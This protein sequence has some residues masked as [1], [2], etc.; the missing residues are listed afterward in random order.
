M[1][2]V[3]ASLELPENRHHRY[4]TGIM[5]ILIKYLLIYYVIS[6][7]LSS[8][9]CIHAY[10]DTVYFEVKE[11]SPAQ[12][13]VG[14]IPTKN[15][16][17]YHFNDDSPIEF[18]LD[19]ETGVLV[20]TDVPL[21]RESI[22]QY[23]FVILSSSPTYP[24]QV[25]IRVLDVNDNWP[26]WPD[27]INT[28]LTFSES[29]PIG[30]RIIL[31]NPFDPDEG[32]L[33]FT[34]N[35]INDNSDDSDDGSTTNNI[36]NYDNDDGDIDLSPFKLNYNAS[37]KF[38]Y[39][40]VSDKLDRELRNNY[41]LNITA[42]DNGDGD[43][44]QQQQHYS[45]AIFSIQIL[46]SND[47]PPIFDHSDYQVSINDSIGKDASILQVHATDA[48]QEQN[49]NS[50]IKQNLKTKSSTNNVIDYNDDNIDDDSR[51]CVFTVFA[52]DHGQPRQDGRTYVTA[53]IIATNNHAPIIKFR[54][55]S[56]SVNANVA[57]NAQN[58]SVVAAI[59]VIDYDRGR[60]GQTWLEIVDGNQL[61]HFRLESLGNSHI[62]KVNSQLDREHI[63]RY[64]LTIMAHDNGQPSK[65]ST[66]NLIIVVQDHNDHGPKFDK[67]IYEATI[68]ESQY[69]IG[70]FVQIIHAT[71]EDVGINAQISYSISGPDSH[72]FHCDQSTGL[73]TT[74]KQIDREQI[75]SFELRITARD[76]ASNPKW[77]HSLLRVKVLD[78]NDCRPE[79]R[80]PSGYYFNEQNNQ[81]EV[82]LPENQKLNLDLIIDDQDLG[83][84]GTVDIKLLYDYNGLFQIDSKQKQQRLIS[85][86]EFDFE[87]PIVCNNNRNYR[88]IL[89]A[90][91]N[92]PEP[93]WSLLTII[94]NIQ[95]VDDQLPELYPKQYYSFIP[96]HAISMLNYSVILQKLQIRSNDFQIP[97]SYRIHDDDDDDDFVRQF[98]HV[99]NQGEMRF[100]N[101]ANIRSL[102]NNRLKNHFSFNIDCIGCAYGH[103]QTRM[104]IFLID[105]HINNN[106]NNNTDFINHPNQRQSYHFKVQENVP[107][108]TIVGELNDINLDRYQLYIIKGDLD[109][110]FR[111]ESKTLKTNKIIDH[112][113]RSHYKLQLIAIRFDHFF[114][115]DL[116]ITII[117]VDD[118]QPYF[119]K[120]FDVIEID[121]NVPIMY[122]VRH[123]NA[124][125]LDNDQNSTII[126][127]LIDNPFDMFKIDNDELKLAKT[128]INNNN[129]NIMKKSSSS[130]I[131]P[132]IKV[133]IEA[134][135][136][137]REQKID[138]QQQQS[139]LTKTT[140]NCYHHDD[141]HHSMAIIRLFIKIKPVLQSEWRKPHFQRKFVEIFLTESIAV[142]EK[143]YEINIEN[144]QNDSFVF[145]LAPLNNEHND[146][147]S[148]MNNFAILP[149]GQLYI[150]Q[151]LD[152]E[153]TDL[154]MFNIN[155]FNA[156]LSVN[157]TV[158]VDTMQMLIH[159]Q[160]VNDNK[161]VFDQDVY[162]FQIPENISIAQSFYIGQVHATDN[163]SGRNAQIVYSI[164]NSYYSSYLEIDPINGYLWTTVNYDREQLQ[165]FEVI[166]QAQDQPIDEKSYQ[167]QTLVRIEILDINDN[168]PKFEV[169]AN[170]TITHQNDDQDVSMF[171]E[172][173]V[174]ETAQI[175]TIL[176]QFE[177]LDLDID[178]K[179]NYR[180]VS[181]ES[182]MI[183]ATIN[184][185]TGLLILTKQLDRETRDNYQLIIE[186]SDGH[187]ASQFYLKILIEDFND[188][189]PEWIN[190]SENL[191]ELNVA[192]NISIGEEIYRFEAIDHD[193][194]S[195]RLFHFAIDNQQQFGRQKYFDILGDKLVV[196]NRLDYEKNHQHLLN[197]TLI[198]TILNRVA[199]SRSIRINIVDINDCLPTF[200][201]RTETEVIRV[202]ENIDIGSKL[203]SLQAY[204]CDQND[205]LRFEI[206]ACNTHYHT[207]RNIYRLDDD[208]GNSNDD[209]LNSNSNQQQETQH[210]HDSNNCPL[211]LNSETGEIIN[212]NNLDREVIESI[213]LRLSVHDN[214]GHLDRMKIIF[215]IDDVND[216]Q[217]MFITP[218]TIVIDNNQQQ[219][220]TIVGS[221]KAIDLDLGVNSAITYKIEYS[222]YGH[223][224][225]LDPFTGVFRTK[226]TIMPAILTDA[227]PIL[228]NV[229][230]TDGG[231]LKTFDLIEFIP[232]DSN[233]P[234][235]DVIDIRLDINENLP[236]STEIH[237]LECHHDH[238]SSSSDCHF[239][240][241]NATDRNFE[242]N[243]IT[244]IITVVDLIDREML[245]KRLLQI[246]VIGPENRY[247]QR[248]NIHINILDQNDNPPYLTNT[249]III[250]ISETLSPGSD[251]FDISKMIADEDLNN[252]F[253]FQIINCSTCSSNSIFA[254]NRKTGIF[255]LQSPLDCEKI[256]KYRILFGVS[257]G[258]YLLTSLIDIH[259]IDENDNQPFFNQSEYIFGIRENTERGTI[260]GQIQAYDADI[261]NKNLIYSIVDDNDDNDD[262]SRMI[263][264]LVS[265]IF[266]LD[267]RSGQF[268]LLK[269]LD[270]EKDS[271]E[272]RLKIIA[273]DGKFRSHPIRV[274]F[275][276]INLSDNPP[277]FESNIYRIDIMENK[278]ANN[279][280]CLQ[281]FDAD[282]VNHQ[283]Q[284]IHD[285]LLN[286][287][288]DV[289]MNITYYLIDNNGDNNNNRQQQQQ[290]QQI[291]I[292]YQT[293]CLSI[294]RPLDHESQSSINLTAIAS[295]G[296]LNTTATL[297]I[298]I[299]DEND[300]YPI[301]SDK[302]S[303]NI[304]MAENTPIDTIVYTFEAKDSDSPP[305]SYVQYELISEN[306][307]TD[308]PFIIGPI[309][310]QLKITSLIDREQN[311]HFDLIIR[312]TDYG[313]RST[314][315]HCRVDIDDLND[316]SPVFR[317]HSYDLNVYENITIGHSVFQLD[318][319]DL[320]PTDEINYKI[321]AGNSFGTFQIDD[322]NCIIV[323][324]DLNFEEINEYNLKINA[325][326]RS[327]NIDTVNIR[328]NIVNVLDEK[329]M[330]DQNRY[331]INWFENQLGVV[332]QFSAR[333]SSQVKH[334]SNENKH[335]LRSLSMNHIN[336]LLMN[337]FNDSFH[338]NSS[339][340][341]LSII[342]PIDREQLQIEQQQQS[343]IIELKLMA[344]DSLSRL[345]NMVK[346]VINIIDIND[347]FPRFVNP[348]SLPSLTNE[349]F[350]LKENFHYDSNFSIGQIKVEDADESDIIEYRLNPTYNGRFLIDSNGWI[351]L[352]Q[353]ST[354]FDRE[355]QSRFPMEIIVSDSKHTIRTNVSIVIDDQNDCSPQIT[356]IN[357]MTT[358]ANSPVL[359]LQIPT[360][361]L[362]SIFEH[363][364]PLIGLEI[365]DCDEG[366]NGRVQV[367]LD[368]DSLYNVFHVD[369][370]T[371]VI[372]T[373]S[374]NLNEE[375]LMQIN[376]ID[377]ILTDQSDT[378][379]LSTEYSIEFDWINDNDHEYRETE[380]IRGKNFIELFISETNVLN[381]NLYQFE[382]NIDSISIELYAGDLYN[383]F[384]I[385]NRSLINTKPLDYETIKSYDLYLQASSTTNHQYQFIFIRLNVVNENDN[386]P[387]FIESIYNVSIPEEEADIF[388]AQVWANDL[389]A[390]DTQIKYSIIDDDNNQLPF[391]I[392]PNTGHIFTTTKI[393]R[394]L[395]DHF[396]LTIAA[397]DD[398]GLK[399]T[400]IVLIN[401]EDKNDNPP[402]FTHLLRTNISEQTSIESFIIQVQSLDKDLGNNSNVTY[403]LLTETE[404]FRIDSFNGNVYLINRLDRERKEQY[405]LTVSADDGSWKSQTTVTI[406]VLDENDCRPEFEQPSYEFNVVYDRF[407]IQ[408]RTIG[409]VRAIDQDKSLNGIVRY[410]LKER[411]KYFSINSKTG[412]I[413]QRQ[414]PSKLYE[415]EMSFLNNHQLTVI[416]MD[417][418]RRPNSNQATILIRYYSESQNSIDNVI[419]IQIPVDLKNETLL[420]TSN[421][422]IRLLNQ[423]NN[424]QNIVR[425]Q[426][427]QLLFNGES[428]VQ[429]NNVYPIR[430]DNN[431]EIFTVNL[432]IINQ[433]QFAPIF[434]KP[435]LETNSSIT[436]SERFVQSN[437]QL[438]IYRF[439]AQD[440]DL[441]IDS[442]NSQIRFSFTVNKLYWNKNLDDYLA[443]SYKDSLGNLFKKNLS[444]YELIDHIDELAGI[445]MPFTMNETTGELKL[446]NNLDYEIITGYSLMITAQ[447]CAWYSKQTTIPFNVWIEDIEDFIGY[448]LI[449]S[450]KL[451]HAS[452][453]K[454]DPMSIGVMV[455]IFFFV[456]LILV[457]STSFLVYHNQRKRLL[458]ETR[459]I[460]NLN[461]NGGCNST[462]RSPYDIHCQ[463]S[464]DMVQRLQQQQQQAQQQQ[465]IINSIAAAAVTNQHRSQQQ[466]PTISASTQHV[467]LNSNLSQ[468]SSLSQVTS[469]QQQQQHCISSPQSTNNNQI[470]NQTRNSI[471]KTT[472]TTTFTLAQ[473]PP[474]LP[475]PLPPS[476]IINSN[477]NVHH[478]LVN[479]PPPTIVSS[480]YTH[481]NSENYTDNYS[482]ILA[483]A[484]H[485][486]LENASSIAPSD[487]DIV[488]HY[489]GYRNRDRINMHHL[490][491]QTSKGHPHHHHHHAP[492]S[493]LSPSVSE[494]SS[495]HPHILTLQDLR[496]SQTNAGNSLA[497]LPLPPP[498]Q[499]PIMNHRIPPPPQPPLP[500]TQSSQSI[501]NKQPTMIDDELENN[502]SYGA[503]SVYTG[504]G[505]GNSTGGGW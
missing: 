262:D 374:R 448:N 375:M 88:L 469:Q 58:G 293:G 236:L 427:N 147:S 131:Y 411:S 455:V 498:P 208:D 4:R 228:V 331:E 421:A 458:S 272:Y 85:T 284:N 38:L 453:M 202:K 500:P 269:K 322:D 240:L 319:Q 393:D 466:Q 456:I 172:M 395:I 150:R 263:N 388:V 241:I 480:I 310:G 214:V 483:S 347:N 108:G 216:E 178:S 344:I 477:P 91:D 444:S 239:Y 171:G 69:Q 192:E 474:T 119:I 325:I 112:E 15:G 2:N 450:D 115:V 346:I 396:R 491:S 360:K 46:D 295:D 135:D 10:S 13:Y 434:T 301:F 225:D 389:D 501:N 298:N 23:N 226:T 133:T 318:A 63:A 238:R 148:L 486:D 425:T 215:I 220:N 281:A 424:D 415:R 468:V 367:R 387:T 472:Q 89:L 270:Y 494:L 376:Q 32:D 409:K 242:V 361:K 80:L 84:N 83:P 259:I 111:L 258:I 343:N 372:K 229:S 412:E 163:D 431:Y 369:D 77:A 379:Q 206:D 143:F 357:G 27:Y 65:Y 363:N 333:S 340:A 454:T 39:L 433:N 230:A 36:T 403:S 290:Q 400:A 134:I 315:H 169:P 487:I 503:Y 287:T 211:K 493:R 187:F 190:F 283:Q 380:L 56:K 467:R 137:N 49:D 130:N 413:I 1:G 113:Y 142:N 185:T 184:K 146:S 278:I 407:S 222:S 497:S 355:Q 153:I 116:N 398:D 350:H 35:L 260:I 306:N 373:D 68:V 5:K 337:N 183:I 212:M 25:K 370:Q 189:Q 256:D 60:N 3:P 7:L 64:N 250:E 377:L 365:F 223:L 200:I 288:N 336:Y 152:R 72:Y 317:Q 76:G 120:P 332:G 161:P 81:Y 51:I 53:R 193:L 234:W 323:A 321:I 348:S 221:V 121:E 160:D 213:N 181:N 47:N 397:T 423:S 312:A 195:N 52:H 166:V 378:N 74:D 140:I 296:Y 499:L 313:G 457:I 289:I 71:D 471:R 62:I 271:D 382:T 422:M 30:T 495:A 50:R 98:F 177:A 79:I 451:Y 154:I 504:V 273:S 353:S 249:S 267:S 352:Q 416:A 244:G 149:N 124:I 385:V 371:G 118:C 188:C 155:M 28:N 362:S 314:D 127:R 302:I 103:N 430:I 87:Q 144:L 327:G 22:S 247:L 12:T 482:N 105:N 441:P 356:R 207:H 132:L 309:D 261:S 107:I 303:R 159:I 381:Q 90:R 368:D 59:S 473:S 426:Y 489:K 8:S 217:P 100:K 110:H 419:R 168:R 106:N 460:S 232:I 167:T 383:Y 136:K 170:V 235:L 404:T 102:R 54:Y 42:Y 490:N 391:R 139:T 265:S 78:Q 231:G 157:N 440:A 73:I 459:K 390:S 300:N 366:M 45:S 432:S 114:Y 334:V 122:N 29:A 435:S 92:G 446:R 245:D 156:E 307:A 201:R 399:S 341:I 174:I 305:N 194:G 464:N 117:N 14:R 277:V 304:R 93:L 330:F 401:V 128:M 402:R 86:K 475:P 297:I 478:Q 418:G 18:H 329:P 67:D 342:R 279:I 408:N 294:I 20:T 19:S 428:I 182:D 204:D 286:Q 138:D 358:V 162:E 268:T 57:E 251:I 203:L 191:L 31:D 264:D 94:V 41:L 246:L 420:F 82:D 179:I 254:L 37:T 338:L 180:L 95:N 96:I 237:R 465:E 488:Y 311:D 280:I 99:N 505:G 462:L 252:K 16:F 463:F 227:K 175:G 129:N 61:G 481:S 243:K 101:N 9:T 339:N 447:D 496:E 109:E 437:Q 299:L 209:N 345:S 126:Y 145:Q 275:K 26:I 173:I 24:I 248:Q 492:L 125:D 285:S 33:Q 392:D 104:N 436:I 479:S 445:K 198:E 196:I 6:S 308:L 320:D 429:N 316:N 439:E 11:N 502:N 449:D 354:M 476:S 292:D 335:H 218:N 291:Q 55:F 199:S 158:P 197:V 123:L 253:D 97:L 233:R 276:L 186:A 410:R 384:S 282:L 176:T 328:I 351:R 414:L 461:I 442:L 394:E 17:H 470:M 274:T 75:D 43:G 359:K 266:S 44:D 70:Q 224:F 443:I 210:K 438:L 255:T 257:D 164:V 34:I 484:E 40:E 452:S 485:Y 364:F 405:F 349:I 151:R 326:D 205:Q 417:S 141:D 324:L 21:D 386:P 48:D 66:D 406:Y 165:R 219:P